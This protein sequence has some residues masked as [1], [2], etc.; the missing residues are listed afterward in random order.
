MMYAL[1]MTN[2]TMRPQLELIVPVS[3][4]ILDLTKAEVQT[5]MKNLN[6]AVHNQIHKI[7]QQR[8]QDLLADVAQQPE[9]R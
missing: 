7:R 1:D 6:A 8:L 3:E 4:D 5:I 2:P 9:A